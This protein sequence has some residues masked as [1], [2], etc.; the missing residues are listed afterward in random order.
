MA[1][2]QEGLRSG[3]ALRQ[4]L[5]CQQVIAT[6][7]RLLFRSCS[8]AAAHSREA[9]GAPKDRREQ[10]REIHAAQVRALQAEH[11]KQQEELRQALAVRYRLLQSVSFPCSMSSSR[12]RDTVTFPALSKPRGSPPQ[13]YRPLLAAAAKG[14]LTRRLLRTERVAQLVRT[15][16]DTQQFLQAFQQQPSPGREFWSRQDL[17][18]QER[19]TLQLRAARY[20][21]YDIF[22]SLSASERMQLIGWDRE[23]TR[24]RE[25]RRQSGNAGHPKRKSSLSAA[26]QKSL[27]R[28]RGV[29]MQKKAAV[30]NGPARTNTRQK[31]GISPEQLP[32]TKAGQF[33]AKP[34]RVSKSSSCSRP[35]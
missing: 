27:E 8:A 34:Q 16:R 20:E 25:H 9:S 33:R 2:Q 29:L 14:F 22:F 26:T 10:L 12:L 17:L 1:E 3:P 31:T 6:C 23:L 7:D 35:R 30:R 28:K 11:R 19:V 13:H 32:E 15:V 24:E 21:V 18:L 5:P 4:V